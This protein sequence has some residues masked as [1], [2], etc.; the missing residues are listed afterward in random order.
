MIKSRK[1][2][3]TL[4]MLNKIKYVEII[5]AEIASAGAMGNA[6]GVMLYLIIYKQFLC[7]EVSLFTEPALYNFVAESLFEH[8]NHKFFFRNP[9][10]K[11]INGGMG[12]SVFIN[13]NCSLS[14][15][16]DLLVY[17]NN[18]LEYQIDC[19]C[20]GVF[21]NVQRFLNNLVKTEDS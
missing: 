9:S 1:D 6:G 4:E 18:K 19:S 5:Y 10:F 20:L 16:P 13:N 8:Q 17:E 2:K 12:N 14:L 7:L 21:D 3:L 11:Y 15:G